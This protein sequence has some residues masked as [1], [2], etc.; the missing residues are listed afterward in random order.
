MAE[1]SLKKEKSLSTLEVQVEGKSIA[2]VCG[3]HH[4]VLTRLQVHTHSFFQFF[5]LSCYYMSIFQLL[6]KGMYCTIVYWVFAYMT[7]FFFR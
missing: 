7:A 1:E 3:L 5:C 6:G 2:A 4:A